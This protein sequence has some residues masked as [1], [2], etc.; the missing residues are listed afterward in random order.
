LRAL[1]GYEKKK[2]EDMKRFQIGN[3]ATSSKGGGDYS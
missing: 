1:A 2:I 3:K